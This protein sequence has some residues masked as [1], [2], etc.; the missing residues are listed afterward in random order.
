MLHLSKNSVKLILLVNL[1]IFCST[2]KMY[3]DD[4]LYAFNKGVE[5]KLLHRLRKNVHNDF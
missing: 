4:K 3:E 2:K 5:K 1:A